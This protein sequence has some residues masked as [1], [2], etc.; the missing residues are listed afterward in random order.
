MGRRR[1]RI[2]LILRDYTKV[3]GQLH[4][5]GCINPEKGLPAATEYKATWDPA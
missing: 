5:L 3:K 1:D 2:E 4:Y